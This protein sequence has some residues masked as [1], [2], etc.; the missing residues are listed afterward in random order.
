MRYNLNL[1]ELPTERDFE[2]WQMDSS[3]VIITEKS[4]LWHILMIIRGTKYV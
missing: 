1:T 4:F 2:Q 3:S